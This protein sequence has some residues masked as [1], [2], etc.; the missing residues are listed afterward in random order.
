MATVE[1][2]V[3]HLENVEDGNTFEEIILSSQ[4]DFPGL[5][6]VL[7]QT[8]RY[9]PQGLSTDCTWCILWEGDMEGT[10]STKL[11]HFLRA[12]GIYHTTASLI[13]DIPFKRGDLV[14][15]ATTLRKAGVCLICLHIEDTGQEISTPTKEE[16]EQEIIDL[17]HE[18]CQ[19]EGLVGLDLKTKLSLDPVFVERI[20]EIFPKLTLVNLDITFRNPPNFDPDDQGFATRMVGAHNKLQERLEDNLSLHQ[21]SFHVRDPEALLNKHLNELYVKKL[22]FILLLNQLGRK[23]IVSLP[24]HRDTWLQILSQCEGHQYDDL[25]VSAKYYYLRRNTWMFTPEKCLGKENERLQAELKTMK[26]RHREELEAKDLEIRR[27]QEALEV[28][29]KRHKGGKREKRHKVES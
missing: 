27:L 22:Q 21:L 23:N 3:I 10:D 6:N 18:V 19:W 26:K 20:A 24:L 8:A 13:V 16:S 25:D 14:K 4:S 11:M 15:M 29:E 1:D 5:A 2:F 28:R 7:D 9:E 17:F 12:I